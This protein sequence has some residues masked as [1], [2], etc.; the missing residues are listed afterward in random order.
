VG[1]NFACGPLARQAACVGKTFARK[2]L[3]VTVALDKSE[4]EKVHL[5]TEFEKRGLR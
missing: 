5:Q 4:L 3:A 1:E 2:P